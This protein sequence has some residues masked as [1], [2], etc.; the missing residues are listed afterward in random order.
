MSLQTPHDISLLITVLSDPNDPKS[1][2]LVSAERR[3]TPTWSVSTLKSKLEPV[4]GIPSVSQT[5]RT[6]NLDNSRIIL[7]PEDALVG[8]NRFGL[9]KG[10]EIEVVDNRPAGARA[11]ID[12]SDLS[13]V[14]KYVMPEQEYEKL[15]DSVL[16]WKKRQGLGRF[17]PSAGSKSQDE[18]VE[19]RRERDR[20]E[21]KQR[22]VEV[23][24][25]CRVN[26]SDERRGVV[27]FVGAVEGL[28]GAK[29]EGCIWIGVE[30][31]EPVGRNDGSVEVE[32]VEDGTKKKVKR[33]VFECK[34]ANY[35]GLVRPERIEVGPQWVVLDELADLMDEDMEEI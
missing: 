23:G 5:L 6:G 7:S 4:T 33:K 32:V 8:D 2:P 26:E 9:T 18:L 25:R 34:G 21:I 11:A 20:S 24:Q 35:G 22:G 12:F 3:I 31:D 29:E 15:D 28:G 14:E 10:S 16:A 30:F 19:E 27:R 17:A 1:K 13:S